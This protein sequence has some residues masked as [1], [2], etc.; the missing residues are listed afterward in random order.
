MNV[1]EIDFRVK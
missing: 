1:Y